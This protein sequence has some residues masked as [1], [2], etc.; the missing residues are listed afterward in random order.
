M[1]I[2]IQEGGAEGEQEPGT[3]SYELMLALLA[4]CIHNKCSVKLSGMQILASPKTGL[5]LNLT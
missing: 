2:F 4:R 1:T 5:K 3:V